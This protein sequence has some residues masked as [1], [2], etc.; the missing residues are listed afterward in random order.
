M[1]A[2]VTGSRAST[3]SGSSQTIR[4]YRHGLA[5]SSNAQTRIDRANAPTPRNGR[6]R[7]GPSL[8]ELDGRRHTEVA[9][10]VH[11]VGIRAELIHREDRARQ[12]RGRRSGRDHDLVAQEILRQIRN[13]LTVLVCVHAEVHR[14][15]DVDRDRA[16]RVAT[17]LRLAAVSVQRSRTALGAEYRRIARLKS[18][19][20][21]VLAVARKLAQLVYRMLRYGHDYVDIGQQA[22]EALNRARRVASLGAAA[23]SLG[24][25]LVAEEAQ[26]TS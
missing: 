1:V 8:G 2:V 18:A 4:R 21:A 15:F 3:A 22:Y 19:P 7:C 12:L 14:L 13:S 17:V 24:Y 16:N 20:V 11:A 23:R 10:A 26:A 9:R 6:G 25:I 5:R